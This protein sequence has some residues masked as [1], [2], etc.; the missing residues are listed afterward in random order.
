MGYC[1][2]L[3]FSVDSV[4]DLVFV[5]LHLL[6]CCLFTFVWLICWLFC[7][8][9]FVGLVGVFLLF[10]LTWWFALVL[11]FVFAGDVLAVFLFCF[12]CCF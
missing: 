6:F 4:C 10:C 7:C 8:F 1:L 9:G 11:L 3:L 12:D 5:V 2:C